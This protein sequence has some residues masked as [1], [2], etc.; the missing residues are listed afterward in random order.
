MTG[1]R[2]VL[3]AL[4]LVALCSVTGGLLWSSWPLLAAA[5][6]AASGLAFEITRLPTRS[7]HAADRPNG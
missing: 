6:A 2:V 3:G 1:R 4:A 5:V 7:S